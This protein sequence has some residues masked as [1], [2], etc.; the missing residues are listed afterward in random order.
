MS[1]VKIYELCLTEL[2]STPLDDLHGRAGAGDRCVKQRPQSFF[3]TLARAARVEFHFFACTAFADT[4]FGAD[5]SPAAAHA[6]DTSRGTSR[7]RRGR[8]TGI[9]NAVEPESEH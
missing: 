1:A 6:D 5:Y 7:Y 3:S 4:G 8:L 2:R 9:C